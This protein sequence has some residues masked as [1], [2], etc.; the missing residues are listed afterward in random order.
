[1]TAFHRLLPF[2]TL[3]KAPA[4]PPLTSV[5]M[6]PG[7]LSMDPG[8]RPVHAA[9]QGTRR[10]AVVGPPSNAWKNGRCC[11]PSPS[12][13]RS[14]SPTARI[15]SS[16][17]RRWS[18]PWSRGISPTLPRPTRSRSSS[19]PERSSRP[20]STSITP[21]SNSNLGSTLEVIGPTAARSPPRPPT[22]SDRQRP[23]RSPAPRPTTTASRSPPQARDLHRRGPGECDVADIFGPGSYT[24]TLRPV[25][26]NQHAGPRR[27]RSGCPEARIHRRR[28]LRVPQRR[29]E[30]PDLRRADR[31]GIHDLR[32][33]AL[34]LPRGRHAGPGHLIHHDHDH[35]HGHAHAQ[36]GPGRSSRS[37]YR[38][39]T[40]SRS[41]PW[42][43]A[44]TAS[45]AR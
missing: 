13:R 16:R 33:L 17:S 24:L 45:S 23:I 14:A 21:C 20:G 34:R 30:H 1:M 43:T 31:A 32:A 10:P 7:R 8:P 3:R 37:S 27:Q 44:I 26:L 11:P 22:S 36:H 35:G 2:S 6:G 39:D 4:R 12:S 29:H 18:R 5:S 40:I 28:P 42:P 9:A 38:R 25:E 19:R 41:R 15:R